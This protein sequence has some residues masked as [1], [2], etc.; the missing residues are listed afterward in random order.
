MNKLF[1]GFLA[2]ALSLASCST[3][4]ALVVEQ[5]SDSM[6][7][8]FVVSR[9]ADGSYGLTH[10]VAEGVGTI[11]TDAKTDKE[12][13]LFEDNTNGKTASNQTYEVENNSLNILFADENNSSLPQISIAD[14]NT[15]TKANDL[16][17]LNNCTL[18]YNT[19][20]T[21]E[22]NFE[23][24][25]GVEV[26]FGTTNGVNDIYLV[27]GVATQTNYTKS[28]TKEAGRSLQIDFVQTLEKSVEKKHPSYYI[29]Q[30]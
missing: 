4:E 19:D 8:S 16:E 1:L 5:T 26:A 24:E 12:I 22:L 18:I 9:N 28:Y 17:L 14:R 21:L 25:D 6:L 30:E 15:S 13:F 10:E 2:I 3:E 27:E 11:Y 7:K 20:G 23:V 29:H